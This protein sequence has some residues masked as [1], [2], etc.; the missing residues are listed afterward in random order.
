MLFDWEFALEI[1]PQLA[2]AAVITIEATILGFALAAMLG[3]VF[4]LLRRSQIPGSACSRAASSSSS[5]R[6]RC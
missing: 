4:A 1:L 6:P 2:R 3:L 5:A